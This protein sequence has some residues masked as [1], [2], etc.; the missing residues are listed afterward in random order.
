MTLVLTYFIIKSS[1]TFLFWVSLVLT[2]MVAVA[3]SETHEEKEK[4]KTIQEPQERDKQFKLM[5]K[6][7]I[8]SLVFGFFLFVLPNEEEAL[9]ILTIGAGVELYTEGEVR[10]TTKK[11]LDLINKYIGI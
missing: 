3:N 11:G 9:K 10:E 7:I 1:L 2:F 6:L 4:E 8:A 5:G